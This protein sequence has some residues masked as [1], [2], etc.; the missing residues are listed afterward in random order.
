MW[1]DVEVTVGVRGTVSVG[2]GPPGPYR[3]KPLAN[4]TAAAAAAAGTS[5]CLFGPKHQPEV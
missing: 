3:T 1:G 2:S 5:G 4:A